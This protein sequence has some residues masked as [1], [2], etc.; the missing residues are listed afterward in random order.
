MFSPTEIAAG[1]SPAPR[2]G[3]TLTEAMPA[4]GPREHYMRAWLSGGQI[5]PADRQDSSLLTVL[6]GSNALLIRPPNAPP[7]QAGDVVDCIAL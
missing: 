6:A 3:A 2:Q 1:K 4:G 5:S 7:A